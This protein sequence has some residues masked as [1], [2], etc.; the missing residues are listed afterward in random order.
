M[1]RFQQVFKLRPEQGAVFNDRQISPPHKC[2]VAQPTQGVIAVEVNPQEAPSGI[3]G[4]AMA[5]PFPRTE[6]KNV[7]GLEGLTMVEGFDFAAAGNYHRQAKFR[8]SASLLPLEIKKRPVALGIRLAGADALPADVCQV[9]R[10]MKQRLVNRQ[11]MAE[12][13]GEAHLL[14]IVNN[15]IQ[16]LSNCVG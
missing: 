2:R 14:G 10:I 8:Q 1:H 9:K 12:W 11:R 16:I 13:A 3:G 15:R 4:R 6:Q 7:P 5:V